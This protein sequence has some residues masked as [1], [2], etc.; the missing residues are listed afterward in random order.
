[1]GREGSQLTLLWAN[2]A[3]HGFSCYLAVDDDVRRCRES[4]EIVSA[5]AAGHDVKCLQIF[6]LAENKRNE[7]TK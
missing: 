7:K 1:V 2:K 6:D 5:R 4:D 3:A